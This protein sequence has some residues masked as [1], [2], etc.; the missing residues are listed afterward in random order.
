MNNFRNQIHVGWAIGMTL[1]GGLVGGALVSAHLGAAP[2]DV[3]GRPTVSPDEPVVQSADY[4]AETLTL[5]T[6]R[7]FNGD[8][9]ATPILL[10][11]AMV[12]V[13]VI[14]PGQSAAQELK[15]PGLMYLN[16]DD[17]AEFP[18]AM[19]MV[20]RDQGISFDRIDTINR[21][22]GLAQLRLAYKMAHG[23]EPNFSAPD[24]VDAEPAGDAESE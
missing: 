13:E 17:L 21:E 6:L 9:D 16:E 18:G 8:P 7:N 19:T 14:F 11:S 3:P 2:L 5:Y 12:D 15:V 4:V 10:V 20:N 23:H 24:D 22:R 1:L